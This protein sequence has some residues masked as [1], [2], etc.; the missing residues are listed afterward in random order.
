MLRKKEPVDKKKM[1]FYK[2][3]TKAPSASLLLLLQVLEL[4]GRRG[5]TLPIPPVGACGGRGSTHTIPPVKGCM[6]VG[7]SVHE[8]VEMF[9]HAL[10]TFSLTF[11]CRIR[12]ITRIKLRKK[13]YLIN[14]AITP[15]RN[16]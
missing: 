12:K 15:L 5:A 11:I 16:G 10:N 3:S 8:F 9:T 2:L 13:R 6:C 4:W 1:V 7:G 14:M